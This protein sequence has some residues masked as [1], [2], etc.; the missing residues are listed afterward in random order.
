[1]T[2]QNIYINYLP[3][4]IFLILTV[5]LAF[6]LAMAGQVLSWIV[7]SHNPNKEKNSPFECGFP[8]FDDARAKFDIRFYLV[9]ILFLVFDLEMAFLI[10][11]G[12]QLKQISGADPLSGPAFIAMM[13]FLSV[14]FVGFIYEWKKGALEWE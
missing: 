10:P 12:I 6:T 1:M 4:L 3:I 13:I 14:L 5:G 11:W 8:E 9:A 2:D 7:G